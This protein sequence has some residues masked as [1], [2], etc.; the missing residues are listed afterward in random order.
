MSFR[1]WH[2]YGYGICADEIKT[3]S[4]ERLESLL[5]LAPKFKAQVDE[6]L[7]EAG[8]TEPT[9]DDYM[10]YDNEY[11]L[12][13][14]TLIKEVIEE[15]EGISMTVCCD[16]EGA[17]YLMYQA[18]YPWHLTAAER[19]LTEDHLTAIFARYLGVLTDENIYI[20]GQ[21][22]ENGG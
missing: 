14:V 2:N 19:D 17:K 22:A 6:W 4:V 16:F 11:D 5:S 20:G 15:T 7:H 12:G 10:E 3:H 13:L 18:Q 21:S 9:W 1:T 8:K